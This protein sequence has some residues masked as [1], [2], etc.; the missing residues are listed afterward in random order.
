MRLNRDEI[1]TPLMFCAPLRKWSTRND[2]HI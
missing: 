1:F 2:I